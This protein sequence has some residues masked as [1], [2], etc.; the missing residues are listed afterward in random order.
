MVRHPH[1]TS[2]GHRMMNKRKTPLHPKE[3]FSSRKVYPNKRLGQNFLRDKKALSRIANLAKLSGKDQ[4]IEIGSGLGALTSTLAES[5][6]HVTAIEKDRK[7]FSHLT[8]LF[9]H[10]PK[11]K[12]ILRDALDVN[13]EDFYK[14]HKIKVIANL[15][16][17]ISSP[18]LF[19]L[20]ETKDLFLSWILMLQ[21]EVGERVTARVGTKKYG[22]ISVL[23]QTYMDVSLEFRVPP[24]SFWPKPKVDSAVLKFVPLAQP[25][26]QTSEEALY[27]KVVR[28]SFS[29]RRKTIG[30]SL[31]SAFAK[32]NSL[33]ALELSDI[34][35]K[36]RAETLSIEEFARLTEN[37]SRLNV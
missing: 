18:V 32:D 26:F 12:L 7:L 37:I 17:S 3:F 11:V 9:K 22:S 21:L 25:R 20:L 6:G 27:E 14:G 5:A 35:Y 16:Y 15:P 31:Q 30:N 23:L 29:S 19:K 2:L 13:F 10:N 4:V 8:D 24:D 33:R 1:Q 36:R 28:A 34:N